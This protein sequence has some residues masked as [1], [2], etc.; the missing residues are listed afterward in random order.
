M[1]A[2]SRDTLITLQ[3]ATTAQDD[4][5][6]QISGWADLGSEWA[7]VFYGRGDERRQAAMEQGSQ[8]VTFQVLS[9][10]TTRAVTVKDR[11]THD[12]SIYDVVGI[13]PMG[14]ATIEFTAI[15]SL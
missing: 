13:A 12:G 9:N 10:E 7:A 15:R 2:G 14:R 11:I 8:A 6:E 5:G 1:T 3:H 4:Y